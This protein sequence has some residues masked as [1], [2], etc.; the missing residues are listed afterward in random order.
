[1]KKIKIAH[2]LHSLGGVDIYLRLVLNNID[3]DAFENIV[4][5]GTKDTNVLFLDKEKNNVKEYKVS[6]FR[7]ISVINDIKAAYH[8]YRILKGK[9][10][11]NTHS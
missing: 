9:T 5:H 7:E 3:T 2:L 11:F 8:V 10:G 4:I 1:M 6:I